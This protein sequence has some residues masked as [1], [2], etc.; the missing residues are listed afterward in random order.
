[1]RCFLTFHLVVGDEGHGLHEDAEAERVLP[2]E[3]QRRD[4]QQQR[5]RHEANVAQQH[6]PRPAGQVDGEEQS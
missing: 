1:M 2:C 6:V 3:G 5:L 4:E